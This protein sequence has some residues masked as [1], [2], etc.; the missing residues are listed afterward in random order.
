[1][2]IG[3]RVTDD[4]DW[5]KMIEDFNINEETEKKVESLLFFKIG[6]DYR[7]EIYDQLLIM[8]KEMD[9]IAWLE[10]AGGS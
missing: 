10:M 4:A 3:V 9:R 1:M 8:L 6:D 7:V 2:L 5:T